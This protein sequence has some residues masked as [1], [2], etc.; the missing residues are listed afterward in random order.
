MKKKKEKILTHTSLFV[1]YTLSRI[2]S[3]LNHLKNDLNFFIY[4]KSDQI[5]YLYVINYIG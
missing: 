5:H 1:E 2:A 4:F 3:I